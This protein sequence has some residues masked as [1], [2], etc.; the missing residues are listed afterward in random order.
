MTCDFVV[1]AMG[2]SFCC[3]TVETFSAV[4]H[5]LYHGD[6]PR[7]CSV[8]ANISS[9]PTRSGL[10]LHAGVACQLGLGQ[11]SD[12]YLALTL[13]PT[14]QSLVEQANFS[15]EQNQARPHFHVDVIVYRYCFPHPA[16]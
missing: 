11:S 14:L 2:A 5:F 9:N 12:V 13:P 8:E 6:F 4:Y 15:R 10:L 1:D 16:W 3:P 7:K